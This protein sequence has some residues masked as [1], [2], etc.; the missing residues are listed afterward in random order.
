MHRFVQCFAFVLLVFFLSGNAY[1][2]EPV[3]PLAEVREDLAEVYEIP[4]EQVKHLIAGMKS[5]IPSRKTV[6]VPVPPDLR[7]IGG[8]S[9]QHMAFANLASEKSPEEM[10]GFYHNAL[11]GMPG[12]HWSEQFEI[13]HKSDEPMTAEK[14]MSFTVPVIEIKALAPDDARLM[15]VDPRVKEQLNSVVQITYSAD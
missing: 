5:R 11:E 3:A 4:R 6:G 10:L 8:G 14:L 9:I 12:W 15:S 2:D 13:F 7:Y 1:P